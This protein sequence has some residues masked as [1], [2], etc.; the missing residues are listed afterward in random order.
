M[1]KKRINNA[2]IM[3]VASRIFNEVLNAASDGEI[4]VKEILNIIEDVMN[5]FGYDLDKIA[6]KL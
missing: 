6:I 4:T 1:D 2:K 5:E 3:M